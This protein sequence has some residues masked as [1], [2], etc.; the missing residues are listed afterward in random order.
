MTLTLNDRLSLKKANQALSERVQ[1]LEHIL[2]SHGI[3]VP[4]EISAASPISESNTAFGPGT[5]GGSLSEIPSGVGHVDSESDQPKKSDDWLPH[6]PISNNVSQTAPST[7]ETFMS[8]D[9]DGH[10]S[11][12][13][14][15]KPQATNPS[16]SWNISNT[17][18][19][20]D[21][22]NPSTVSQEPWRSDTAALIFDEDDLNYSTNDDIPVP[23]IPPGR[24]ISAQLRRQSSVEWHN[25]NA[26]ANQPNT[27]PTR[28]IEPVQA[29][30]SDEMID[31]LSAR[32]GSFQLAEDGQLRYFGATSN[33]H[34]LHNGAFSLSRTPTRSIRTDGSAGLHRAGIGKAVDPEFEKHLEHLYFKWEDPAIHVVD[35]EMYYQ[36]Q[37]KWNRGEDGSPFYS[38]TLKNAM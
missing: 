37:E 10:M 18:A 4:S 22:L 8:L 14:T 2:I 32:M 25:D 28:M 16:L 9:H 31:Q 27:S 6:F 1:L 30:Q 20:K 13:A 17:S 34:I 11:A 5:A 19:V 29:S 15:S 23:T 12:P 7:W 26:W 24:A 3:E 21:N 33:L 36:E 35:E 38:E